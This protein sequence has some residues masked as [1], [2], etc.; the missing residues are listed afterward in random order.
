MVT[1]SFLDLLLIFL[2]VTLGKQDLLLDLLDAHLFLYIFNI[3]PY[4]FIPRLQVVPHFSQAIVE[5]MK[6]RKLSLI[7]PAWSYIGVLGGH[8]NGGLISALNIN[9]QFL[10]SLAFLIFKTL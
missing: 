4:A 6:Y 1:L 9:I 3:I 7:S 2:N 8:I 10:K 5:G